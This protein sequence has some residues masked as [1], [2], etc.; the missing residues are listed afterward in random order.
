MTLFTLRS[1]TMTLGIAIASASA[2]SVKPQLVAIENG[3]A[4]F[5]VRTNI[6]ALEV[7]GKSASLQARVRM[8]RDS[9]GVKLEH[10]EAWV[11]ATT[12]KTGMSLRDEHMRKRIFTTSGGEVPDLRFESG[13]VN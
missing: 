4:S 10:I 5:H 9:D 12:L 6:P 7:S 1:F 8:H 11:S 2:Q 3:V 13:D